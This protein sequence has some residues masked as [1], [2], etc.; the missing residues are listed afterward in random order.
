MTEFY[1][2]MAFPLLSAAIHIQFQCL[3]CISPTN[4]QLGRPMT[5]EHPVANDVD[6]LNDDAVMMPNGAG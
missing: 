6:T 3:R 4:P 2:D 1:S 5:V